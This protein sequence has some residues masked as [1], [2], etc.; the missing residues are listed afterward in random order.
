MFNI[1]YNQ[2][3]NIKKNNMSKE[4]YSKKMGKS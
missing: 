2:N 3:I 1:N 4:I